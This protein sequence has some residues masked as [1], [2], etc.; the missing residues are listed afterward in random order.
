M[1]SN[2]RKSTGG[3]AK[4][5]EDRKSYTS[6]LMKIDNY[7]KELNTLGVELP[8]EVEGIAEMRKAIGVL[9]DTVDGL[10]SQAKDLE[11]KYEESN[12]LANSH[13]EMFDVSKKTI[14]EELA[15]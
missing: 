15:E 6:L 13:K 1:A 5:W 8:H 7:D 2:D 11:N 12:S 14:L 4:G 3:E 10:H 9:S